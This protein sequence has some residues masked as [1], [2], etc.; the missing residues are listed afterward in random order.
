M[1][2]LQSL[3][4]SQLLS[5]S[6]LGACLDPVRLAWTML[7]IGPIAASRVVVVVR[8]MMGHRGSS[9]VST[10]RDALWNS[11]RYP[12]AHIAKHIPPEYLTRHEGEV[13]LASRMGTRTSNTA[14]R[15]SSDKETR[16]RKSPFAFLPDERFVTMTG[17]SQ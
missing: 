9:P 4:V 3:F 17:A 8:R 6:Q 12:S 11:V 5:I 2:A 13:C 10:S 16:D 14:E 15:H 1:L 7:S